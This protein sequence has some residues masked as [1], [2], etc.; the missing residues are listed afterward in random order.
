MAPSIDASRGRFKLCHRLD[1]SFQKIRLLI[2]S[3]SSNTAKELPVSI[4]P[5]EH[6]PSLFSAPEFQFIEVYKDAITKVP[7]TAKILYTLRNIKNIKSTGKNHPFKS[8]HPPMVAS[9]F[10]NLPIP[11]LN[12]LLGYLLI[13]YQP[14]ILKTDNQT[15]N[16]YRTHLHPEVLASCRLFYHIG[17]PLL[18][19]SNT[20]TTSSPA[21]SKNFDKHLLDLPGR[22]RQLIKHVKLEIDWADELWAKFPLIARV[23]G[24]IV[25]LKSLEIVISGPVRR[26]GAGAEMML[27]VEEKCF[28]DLAMDDLKALRV[29]KLRGFGNKAFAEA[30]EAWVL[31]GRRSLA[32]L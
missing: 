20:I 17:M 3:K 21:T 25:G 26:H 24:E 8:I 16:N 18:Y 31:S 12:R 29:F 7:E 27:K 10:Q 2:S 15:P 32:R 19:G 22:H 28:A 23:L 13:S 14:L 4:M 5:T 9:Y 1:R 30:L 11:V 6:R